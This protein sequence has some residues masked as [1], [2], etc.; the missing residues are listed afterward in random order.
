MQWR[1]RLKA[2]SSVFLGIVTTTMVCRFFGTLLIAA[3]ATRFGKINS[4]FWGFSRGAF[5]G[6]S[7]C[8]CTQCTWRLGYDSFLVT[9]S[10]WFGAMDTGASRR[11]VLSPR[12]SAWTQNRLGKQPP[13]K[14]FA[15]NNSHT[16][17]R[18]SHLQQQLRPHRVFLRTTGFSRV[19]AQEISHGRCLTTLGSYLG[20]SLK[21]TGLRDSPLKATRQKHAAPKFM[22]HMEWHIPGILHWN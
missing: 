8:P 18:L 1:P 13:L 14:Q 5:L 2:W 10:S 11:C 17:K 22:F 19:A 21:R 7:L 20:P 4:P 6:G 15:Q 9:S 12:S 16:T 3:T